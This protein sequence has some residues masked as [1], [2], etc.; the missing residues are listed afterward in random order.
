MIVSSVQP[1]CACELAVPKRNNYFY[2]QLL[3]VRQ[4]ELEAEYHNYK[5]WLLNRLVGGCGV[6]CGLDVKPVDSPEGAIVIT[7]GFAIDG[8]GRE[9]IVP[10]QTEPQT[11]PE[12]VLERAKS[13]ECCKGDDIH[14]HVVLCYHECLC[15]PTPVLASDCQGEGHCQPAVVCERY[16]VE[17]KPGCAPHPVTEMCIP[18]CI[19]AGKLDYRCLVKAISKKCPPCPPNPCIPL[20]N[21][22]VDTSS[23][24]CTCMPEEIDIS[25]RPIVY[26]NDLLFQL[27]LCAT[28]ETSYQR[29][30]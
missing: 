13:P 27:L 28:N 3:D 29:L 25:V 15:E 23:D 26:G 17:F 30:K 5:R 22:C 12:D 14:V 16:K 7:P 8:H 11:V 24:R 4:F 9:I 18:D 21:I 1:D 10:E 20:A 6:V 2:G 19:S